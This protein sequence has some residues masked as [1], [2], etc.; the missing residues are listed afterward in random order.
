MQILW[1][2]TPS[3]QPKGRE[4][5]IMEVWEEAGREEEEEEE[6]IQEEIRE[7]LVQ[8]IQGKMV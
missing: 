4:A 8:E 3:F 5:E 2:V 6:E 7:N 1:E